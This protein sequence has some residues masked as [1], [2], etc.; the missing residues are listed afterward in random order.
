MTFHGKE[1]FV[2]DP[3]HH[4]HGHELHTDTMQP[5]HLAHAPHESPW[6][7]TL[8]L[9]LLAIPSVLIGWLDDRPDAVRRLLRPCDPSSREANNVSA[10][11]RSEFHGPLAHGAAW[12][13]AARRSGSRSRAFAVATYVWL[14]NPGDADKAQNALRPIYSVLVTQVLGRRAVSGGVRAR[15]RRARPR[16]VARRRCRR[17]RW[18]RDQRLRRARRAHR[19]TVRWLQSGYLYH[20]AFA[21]I[22]GLIALLGGLWWLSAIAAA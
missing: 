11:S 14:L 22:L 16:P 6:V 21:M 2:V 20:Y 1:R 13:R 19:G 7:V 3:P 10:R 15:Q 17:D 8:P 18:R 5:G 9:I 12:I 4:G